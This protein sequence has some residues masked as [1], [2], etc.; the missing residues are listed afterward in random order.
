MLDTILIATIPA[1]VLSI[2]SALIAWFTSKKKYSVEV[3]AIDTDVKS[4]ELR[5]QQLQME[6]YEMLLTNV[7]IRLERV[8]DEMNISEKHF[9]EKAS[10]CRDKLEGLREELEKSQNTVKELLKLKCVVE[11]CNNRTP[12]KNI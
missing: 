12:P 10:E 3:K 2:I 5:N 7:S 9:I 1:A 11:N 8:L 4:V 6:T